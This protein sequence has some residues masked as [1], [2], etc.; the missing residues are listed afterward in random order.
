MPV[1]GIRGATT[2]A[3]NT[4]Q[5]IL[6]S[7]QE[8]LRSLLQANDLQLDDIAAAFFTT[9]VDLNTTYPALGARLL[10]WENVP[11]MC[12]H[13]MKVPGSLALC[14]RV[15]LLVNT[16]KAA[17]EVEHVYLKGAANLR[18]RVARDLG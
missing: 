4:R 17:S 18:Q 12:S 1:R 8:L 2:A 16:E 13:E 9:T 3:S 14:I 5:D 15:M 11:L 10:G 7:T 6:E